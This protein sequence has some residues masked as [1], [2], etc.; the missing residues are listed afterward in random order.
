M[1]T[2]FD[3]SGSPGYLAFGGGAEIEPVTVEGVVHSGVGELEE[4][5]HLED[6][7]YAAIFNIDGCSCAYDA[8]FDEPSRRLRIERCLVGEGE[9]SDGVLH[10]LDLDRSSGRFAVAFS[11]ATTPTQLY[12]LGEAEADPGRARASVPSG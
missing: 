5:E 4:L 6:D 2:V 12:V 9:L 10:G 11:T 8:R 1:T 3:D 7:R